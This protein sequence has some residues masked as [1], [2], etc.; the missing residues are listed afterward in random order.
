MLT[1]PKQE[2]KKKQEYKQGTIYFYGGIPQQQTQDSRLD[3]AW[4][5]QQQKVAIP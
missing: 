3:V 1:C 5:T 4:E 2:Y